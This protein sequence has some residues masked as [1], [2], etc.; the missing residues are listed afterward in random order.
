MACPG[1]YLGLLELAQPVQAELLDGKAAQH[2]TI[3]HGAAERSVARVPR[4]GQIAHEA[5]G[6]TSP[7]LR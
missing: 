7:P 6:E 4:T 1:V 2:G 3:D 5:A